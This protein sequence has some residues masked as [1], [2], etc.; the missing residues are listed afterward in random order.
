[1]TRTM[2]SF[3]SPMRSV[4]FWGAL[5]LAAIVVVTSLPAHAQTLAGAL[6]HRRISVDSS[7]S[8]VTLTLFGNIEPNT[9]TGQKF[10]TGPF[11]IVVVI[12]G[13]ATDRVARR[14]TPE[15][16][17][18][19]NTQSVTFSNFPSYKWV[20]S[21]KPLDQVA[22]QAVLDR[23]HIKLDSFSD[24]VTASGNGD[25]EAFKA[26][27]VR[28]MQD[29]KLFGVNPEG[30]TFESPTLYSAQVDIP[31]D[32]ANG[33]FLAETYLFKNNQLI[34]RKAELFSVRKTGFER[35][36]GDAARAW[37]LWYGIATV[38]LG[39]FTGW[40]GGVVFRR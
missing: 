40:L 8:G 7:F 10:V 31:G 11:D 30:I 26:E 24:V 23:L 5:L 34:T 2:I 22:P 17:L 25:V 39:V 12:T 6:S 14:K 32:V 35:F 29:K 1:M 15:L 9:E 21:D 4:S 37:P 13:P 19:L 27:L 33:T 28:L 18:W 3:L 20:L 16:G 36:L 38:L